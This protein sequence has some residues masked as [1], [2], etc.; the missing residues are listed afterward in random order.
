MRFPHA[1]QPGCQ[2]LQGDPPTYQLLNEWKTEVA[3]FLILFLETRALL[4]RGKANWGEFSLEVE[5]CQVLTR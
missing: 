5:K 1:A 4:T 3:L 2:P